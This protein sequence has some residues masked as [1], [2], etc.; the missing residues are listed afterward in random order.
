MRNNW[1]KK[2]LVIGVIV[3]FFGMGFQPVFAVEN[4]VTAYIK[5]MVEDCDCQE[6]DS[7]NLFRV[8]LLMNN[9]KFFT[10][11]L[12]KRFGHIPEI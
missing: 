12:I 5:E 3:L 6:V 8:K 10:N 9:L 11:I 4:R 7:Q 1:N 2:G